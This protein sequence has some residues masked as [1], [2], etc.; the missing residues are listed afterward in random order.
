M[1]G[2]NGKGGLPA[3]R[4]LCII[5]G[6]ATIPIDLVAMFILPD[7]SAIT[8]WLTDKGRNVTHWQWLGIV[9][10]VIVTT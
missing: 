4:W 9:I 6:A 10:L 7:Y 3:W 1:S 8:K 2:M 5:E